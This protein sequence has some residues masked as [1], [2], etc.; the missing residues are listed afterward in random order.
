MFSED[1]SRANHFSTAS[2]DASRR[3]LCALRTDGV[4]AASPQCPAHGDWGAARE[5]YQ[6]LHVTLP[7][8]ASMKGHDSGG[9][10]LE[11]LGGGCRAAN[12]CYAWH[13]LRARRSQLRDDDNSNW[14]L[15]QVATYVRS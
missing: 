9:L 7:A 5:G 4:C 13:P 10:V 11:M 6:L 8:G 3:G 2:I 12:Q 1:H 15:Q 14:L